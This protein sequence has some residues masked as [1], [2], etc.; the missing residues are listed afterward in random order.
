[1]KI[2]NLEIFYIFKPLFLVYSFLCFHDLYFF[3]I[4]SII[5]ISNINIINQKI[6]GK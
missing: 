4:T 5:K 6:Y 3:S 1:M 2:K